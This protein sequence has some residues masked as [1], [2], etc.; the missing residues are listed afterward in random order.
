[1][2]YRFYRV[3]YIPGGFLAGFLNHQPCHVFSV[4]SSSNRRSKNPSNCPWRERDLDLSP[5]WFWCWK[6]MTMRKTTGSKIEDYMTYCW[7]T[8]SCTTKDD[9]FPI[10][11]EVLPIQV[12]QVFFHQHE[13]CGKNMQKLCSCWSLCNQNCVDVEVDVKITSICCIILC[14]WLWFQEEISG[15]QHLR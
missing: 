6:R 11:D 8:K 4:S 1:M 5:R 15:I 12:M 10:I 2:I 3:L 14:S 9:D 13:L 7:W